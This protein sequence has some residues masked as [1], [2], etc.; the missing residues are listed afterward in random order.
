MQSAHQHLFDICSKKIEIFETYRD[1]S[2]FVYTTSIMISRGAV[3]VKN[4]RLQFWTPKI[5]PFF[6][7]KFNVT[8]N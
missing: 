3:K 8:T 2:V 1:I 4:S 6:F 7:T 5:F